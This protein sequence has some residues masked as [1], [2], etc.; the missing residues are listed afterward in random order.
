MRKYGIENFIVEKLEEVEDESK[1][2]E[3]EQYWISELETY[4]VH[5]YNA[6]KGGDG[7]ILY[8]YNEVV[9]LYRLGHSLVEVAEMVGCNEKTVR[10][11]LRSKG[12]KSRGNFKTVYQF[13][14]E[15]KFIQEFETSQEAAKF[16]INNNLIK[17]KDIRGVS[18]RITHNCSGISKSS[19]GY[20]WKYNKD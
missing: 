10:N 19:Y 12:I 5:G 8:D 20:L 13:S 9:D 18:N 15:G 17:S 1:L 11:I 16:L 14:L 7:A 4:G 2:S 6:T 3:R